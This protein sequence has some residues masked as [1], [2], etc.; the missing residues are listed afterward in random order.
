MAVGGS[1]GR[2]DAGLLRKKQVA[3][4]ALCGLLCDDASLQKAAANTLARAAPTDSAAL[5]VLLSLVRGEPPNLMPSFSVSKSIFLPHERWV[6]GAAALGAPEAELGAN[7]LR[8][9]LQSPEAWKRARVVSLRTL[10]SVYATEA[11]HTEELLPHLVVGVKREAE[12]QLLYCRATAVELAVAFAEAAPAGDGFE[13]AMLQLA[14]VNE[15]VKLPVLYAVVARAVRETALLRQARNLLQRMLD[16]ES[17]TPVFNVLG[18]VARSHALAPFALV[19]FCSVNLACLNNAVPHALRVMAWHTA[20]SRGMRLLCFIALALRLADIRSVP[21]RRA[22]TIFMQSKLQ[23][24]DKGGFEDDL[25]DAVISRPNVMR[26]AIDAVVTTLFQI[27]RDAQ[28]IYE[29]VVLVGSLLDLQLRATAEAA[30]TYKNKLPVAVMDVGTLL[31]V[32]ALALHLTHCGVALEKDHRLEPL[33]GSI[34]AAVC[35][36]SIEAYVMQF[37]ISHPFTLEETHIWAD[38]A[39]LADDDLGLG[40]FNAVKARP[41]AVLRGHGSDGRGGSNARGAECARGCGARQ[42]E[43]VHAGCHE[44]GAGAP[45]AERD[46]PRVVADV[47]LGA[48]GAQQRAGALLRVGAGRLDAVAGAQLPA[49]AAVDGDGSDRDEPGDAGAAVA[50]PPGAAGDLQRFQAH[51]LPRGGAAVPRGGGGVLQVRRQVAVPALA[52]QRGAERQGARGPDGGAAAG[53]DGAGAGS[54]HAGLPCAVQVPAG[55]RGEAGERV[56]RALRGAPGEGDRRLRANVQERRDGLQRGLPGLRGAALQGEPVE[57]GGAQRGGQ[58]LLRLPADVEP[59]DPGA[60]DGRG[61][62]GPEFDIA[63][64]AA[65]GGAGRPARRHRGGGAAEVA[66]LGEAGGAPGVA[67]QPRKRCECTFA[68]LDPEFFEFDFTAFINA[69]AG[70]ESGEAAGTHGQ[71][72]LISSVLDAESNGVSRA[73][74]LSRRNEVVL[75]FNREIRRATRELLKVLGFSKPTVS[76]F[77]CFIEEEAPASRSNIGNGPVTPLEGAEPGVGCLRLLHL[78]ALFRLYGIRLA[79]RQGSPDAMCQKAYERVTSAGFSLGSGFLCDVAL[80]AN[81]PENPHGAELVTHMLLYLKEIGETLEGWKGD[82]SK[83][84]CDKAVVFASALGYMHSRHCVVTEFPLVVVGLLRAALGR[85]AACAELVEALCL[86]LGNVYRYINLQCYLTEDI[87]SLFMQYLDVAPAGEYGLGWLLGLVNLIEDIPRASVSILA[88]LVYRLVEIVEGAESP[89]RHAL[90]GLPLLQYWGLNKCEDVAVVLAHLYSSAGKTPVADP[91]ELLFAAYCHY[92]DFQPQAVGRGCRVDGDFD[93]AS[94]AVRAGG[95]LSNVAYQCA[96]GSAAKASQCGGGGTAGCRLHGSKEGAGTSGDQAC[97]GSGNDGC[98][99]FVYGASVRPLWGGSYSDGVGVEQ[100][101][102]TAGGSGT[103]TVSAGQQSKPSGGVWWLRNALMACIRANVGGTEVTRELLLLA[104]M[105]THGYA[106]IVPPRAERVK[107]LLRDKN[108]WS[109]VYSELVDALSAIGREAVVTVTMSTGPKASR[110]SRTRGSA[111]AAVVNA[112]PKSVLD[113][114]ARWG[115]ESAALVA[116]LQLEQIKGFLAKHS[117][118]DCYREDGSIGC[119]MAALRRNSHSFKLL[120]ALTL[121]KPLKL[122]LW[123]VVSFEDTE[124]SCEREL[125]LRVYCLHGQ[126]NRHLLERL[127]SA[128]KYFGCF[129][130]HLKLSFLNCVRLAFWSIDFNSLRMVLSYV[131]DL[132]DMDVLLTIETLLE[133]CVY[134]LHGAEGAGANDE[135]FAAQVLSKLLHPVIVQVVS[136]SRH[137]K[138]A[139]CLYRKAMPHLTNEQ[140]GEL[141]VAVNAS[142]IALKCVLCSV[143]ET[144]GAPFTFNECFAHLVTQSVSVASIVLYCYVN[145]HRHLDVMLHC[146]HVLNVNTN[147]EQITLVALTLMALVA[148]RN[149]ACYLLELAFDG[150]CWKASARHELEHIAR[151]DIYEFLR[152]IREPNLFYYDTMDVKTL[153]KS[154]NVPAPAPGMWKNCGLEATPLGS[155]LPMSRGRVVPRWLPKLG[156]I[157]LD[158][159]RQSMLPMALPSRRFIS[160]AD[161]VRAEHLLADSALVIMTAYKA[162]LVEHHPPNPGLRDVPCTCDYTTRGWQWCQSRDRALRGQKLRLVGARP[163]TAGDAVKG[164]AEQAFEPVEVVVGRRNGEQL[165]LQ[166]LHHVVA[167]LLEQKTLRR[168]LVHDVALDAQHHAG[169]HGHEAVV[170]ASGEPLAQRRNVELGVGELVAEAANELPLEQHLHVAAASRQKVLVHVDVGHQELQ[171]G[172]DGVVLGKVEPLPAQPAVHAAHPLLHHGVQHEPLELEAV[173]GLDVVGADGAAAVRDG[174]AEH[175]GPGGDRALLELLEREVGGDVERVLEHEER[176]AVDE[177]GLVELVVHVGEGVEDHDVELALALLAQDTAD[178]AT[179]LLRVA[180]PAQVVLEVLEEPVVALH[181]RDHGVGSVAL[182]DGALVEVLQVDGGVRVRALGQ[183]AGRR[184]ELAAGRPRLGAEGGDSA[185]GPEAAGGLRTGFLR[186]PDVIGHGMLEEPQV[187]L[188][189]VAHAIPG[190]A[191]LEDGVREERLVLRL[192]V[193]Q[194]VVVGIVWRQRVRRGV[195]RVWELWVLG[196]IWPRVGGR[197]VGVL[198]DGGGVPRIHRGAAVN[199]VAAVDVRHQGL[200]ARGFGS[201][202]RLGRRRRQWLKGVVDVG[203]VELEVAGGVP[204]DGGHARNEPARALD[205]VGV[206]EEPVGP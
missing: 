155:L 181:A 12:N 105:L 138:L 171:N 66:A 67:R 204:L 35:D 68:K 7:T 91:I 93:V 33:L 163:G 11:R 72:L 123:D 82:A 180:A 20:E 79:G 165:V 174:V 205:G 135:G 74:L 122:S 130:R 146:V 6:D 195:A 159:R 23:G 70:D 177:G 115:D 134:L 94:N 113:D 133:S 41:A 124:C 13:F 186:V 40:L 100:N 84:S 28:P 111:A 200:E 10:L 189:V 151:L 31:K 106:Y 27:N 95:S 144:G 101:G 168:L 99:A 92:M 157:A 173:H 147:S 136:R 44:G 120:S 160:A 97:A 85:F 83:L 182:V 36:E 203:H 153:S 43:L 90:L 154:A 58:L 187:P 32:R 142:A 170:E 198:T 125:V 49:A 53:G 78:N 183:G 116:I 25:A 197:A 14:L 39:T 64:A 54:V 24:P 188:W 185:R 137:Y 184:E 55:G 42:R 37:D 118:L 129:D 206:L 96:G 16:T 80:L 88:G 19:H 47:H 109:S 199:R 117:D 121:C 52:L 112:P 15:E 102:G 107:Q 76:A 57:R 61:R 132:D 145:L 30:T 152:F 139:L 65:A 98:V 48:G 178:A 148:E 166:H 75:E 179:A 3:R 2:R 103:T 62:G 73:D 1:G 172:L 81:F 175:G 114:H 60:G 108:G 110:Y 8:D 26:V 141:A 176:A 38:I 127:A 71:S 126:A 202:V 9:S 22:Y 169:S 89:S 167:V 192:V 201:D 194:S 21:A 140:R 69:E 17:V 50:P 29:L 45:D 59:A 18:D 5:E 128:A 196:R 77:R 104:A 119:M 191:P 86:V 164:A 150:T 158:R 46:D 162:Y 156:N 51:I 87:V 56:R 190:A 143:R 34:V 193:L 131:A 4:D 149:V 63:D 161:E